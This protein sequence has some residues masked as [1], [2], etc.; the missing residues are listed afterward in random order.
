MELSP[1][2]NEIK[3]LDEF[4]LTDNNDIFDYFSLNSSLH[5]DFNGAPYNKDL[6]ISITTENNA[7][8]ICSK[9]KT[10][11]I[12]GIGIDLIS[13]KRMKKMHTFNNHLF[14]DKE[15]I[16]INNDN[17][18]YLRFIS[19]KEASFKALSNL[20]R[21]E[22]QKTNIFDFEINEN[23]V[24]C[25]KKTKKIVEKYH[26]KIIYQLIENEEYYFAICVCQKQ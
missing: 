8:L 18:N 22:R 19:I 2:I 21:K 25:H 14:Y 6:F 26:A 7:R 20:Y 4:Y 3:I 16:E 9:R 1:I 17:N 24:I 15:I 10:N 12:Y 23:N 13:K 5:Y 11:N